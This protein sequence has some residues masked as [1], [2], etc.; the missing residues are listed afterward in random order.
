MSVAS[1]IACESTKF[2]SQQTQV[3]HF[4]FYSIMSKCCCSRLLTAAF[5][6][7]TLSLSLSVTKEGKQ[8]K[9]A[10]NERHSFFQGYTSGVIKSEKIHRK[11]KT[12]SIN[13]AS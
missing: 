10:F 6:S 9:G 2:D 3:R 13:F 1:F 5:S 7:R 4:L 11:E 12:Y 8:K